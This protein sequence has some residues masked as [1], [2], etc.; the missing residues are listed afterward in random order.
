MMIISIPS[1]IYFHQQSAI[2]MKEELE[3]MSIAMDNHI[4]YNYVGATNL[5]VVHSV[6]LA[7]DFSFCNKF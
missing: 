7:I 2:T 4:L 1:L 3:L 6:P 5:L